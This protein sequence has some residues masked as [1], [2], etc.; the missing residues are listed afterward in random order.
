[1]IPFTWRILYY[2]HDLNSNAFVGSLISCRLFPAR[3]QPLPVSE[4]FHI[5]IHVYQMSTNTAEHINWQNIHN[6]W[7]SRRRAV[8]R[9]ETPLLDP[10]SRH[11]PIL[12]QLI[13]FG[14]YSGWFRK[15]IWGRNPAISLL[16]HVLVSRILSATRGWV[17]YIYVEFGSLRLSD[18]FQVLC[19]R[20]LKISRW[21]ISGWTASILRLPNLG[22]CW[23]FHF[24]WVY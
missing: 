19:G 2:P 8:G 24:R 20:L 12:S 4:I 5:Y 10:T 11:N 22:K 7:H 21:G 18:L 1:M 9:W 13:T 6:L 16:R 17:L 15:N 3:E 23:A 14:R